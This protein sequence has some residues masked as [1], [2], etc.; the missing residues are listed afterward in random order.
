M[1]FRQ[2]EKSD[3]PKLREF[4][5]LAL[6]VPLGSEPLPKKI[7]FDPSIS[8]YV[9]D[10]GRFGDFGLF[11]QINDTIV[12]AIW[13]R[14]WSGSNRGYGYW[15]DSTPELSMSVVPEHRNQGI[16]TLL[17]KELISQVS[18]RFRIISLSVSKSNPARRLYERFGFV[19]VQSDDSSLLMIKHMV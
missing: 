12:G 5:Y 19:V 8:K 11:C 17:L 14:F 6:H 15:N 2:I 9:E 3:E 13:L 16:G 1:E 4:L 18:G 7:V 10:W